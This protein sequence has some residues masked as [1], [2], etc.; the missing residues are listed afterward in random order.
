M[1][2]LMHCA[3]WP[4]ENSDSY[5]TEMGNCFNTRMASGHCLLYGVLNFKS[6]S[7]HLWTQKGR[8][9]PTITSMWTPIYTD[10]SLMSSWNAIS[11]VSSKE[12]GDKIRS[13]LGIR[14]LDKK[15]YTKGR[16][17]GW[18]IYRR[19]HEKELQRHFCIIHQQKNMI[20]ED[21]E[22]NG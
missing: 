10:K 13:Q 16:K 2:I 14:N 5:V 4:E 6:L 18:N 22:E 11:T 19:C 9:I 3:W 1:L 15:N 21:Q 8:E 12:R 7:V 20:S 17:I